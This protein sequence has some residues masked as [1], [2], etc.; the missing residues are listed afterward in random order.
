MKIYLFEYV[1]NWDLWLILKYAYFCGQYEIWIFKWWV[2][3]YLIECDIRLEKVIIKIENVWNK[4][5]FIVWIVENWEKG[6]W[7][8]NKECLSFSALN[9]TFLVATYLIPRLV[10]HFAFLIQYIYFQGIRTNCF[11]FPN[12]I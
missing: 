3:L 5:I 9:M 8:E 11:L 7:N 6:F 2:P 4:H 1:Y 10:L 12:K